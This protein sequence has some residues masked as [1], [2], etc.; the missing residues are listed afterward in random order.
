MP[1]QNEELKK[2]STPNNQSIDEEEE[3][4]EFDED[5]DEEG[6]LDL[7]PPPTDFE[8]FKA[9][10]FEKIEVQLYLIFDRLSM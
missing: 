2:I 9:F 5:F 6:D 10:D 8:N 4:Q 3:E 1:L 7:P